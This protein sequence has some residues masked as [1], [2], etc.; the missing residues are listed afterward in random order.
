MQWTVRR[1]WQVLFAALEPQLSTSWSPVEK[2]QKYPFCEKH[3]DSRERRQV[4]RRVVQ[5]R[6]NPLG[7]YF[8]RYGRN[9]LL[10]LILLFVCGGFG[11]YIASRSMS[12]AE[13]SLNSTIAIKA[14]KPVKVFATVIIEKGDTLSSIAQR[15]Y[16]RSNRVEF[17][18]QVNRETLASPDSLR[19]G[20]KVRV[21]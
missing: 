20:Q 16:G 10:L 12:K 17:L 6:T 11:I 7:A 15:A 8:T 5:R 21:P 19:A 1:E 9:G 14:T 2:I 13:Q 4:D 3:W 18:Y